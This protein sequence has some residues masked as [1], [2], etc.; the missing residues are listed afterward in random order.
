MSLRE[1]NMF[2]EQLEVPVRWSVIWTQI[3]LV[4]VYCDYLLKA[5]VEVAEE[6]K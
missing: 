4:K 2:K 6:V 3:D 5:F 1:E